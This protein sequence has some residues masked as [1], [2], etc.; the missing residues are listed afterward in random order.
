M[1]LLE[2]ETQLSTAKRLSRQHQEQAFNHWTV[3]CYSPA[4]SG[5]AQQA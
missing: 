5:E 2:Y 1:L 3:N 4:S